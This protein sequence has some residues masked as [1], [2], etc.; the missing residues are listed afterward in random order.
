MLG[1]LR[2]RELDQILSGDLH[3]F[4]SGLETQCGLVSQALQ[5]RYSLEWAK[6]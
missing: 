4:L 2:Y 6:P 1:E 5:E 3:V